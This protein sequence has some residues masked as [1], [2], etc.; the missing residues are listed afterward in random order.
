M[1]TP[2]ATARSTARLLPSQN[3]HAL[4]DPIRDTEQAVTVPA[5]FRTRHWPPFEGC[6][7]VEFK[8]KFKIY[9]YL[10][11]R[12]RRRQRRHPSRG[13]ASSR[14][15][16]PACVRCSPF[17]APWYDR[18]SACC[19]FSRA[20]VGTRPSVQTRI[21]RLATPKTLCSSSVGQHQPFV[22]GKIPSVRASYQHD[23]LPR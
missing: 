14:L 6:V 4:H 20:C 22:C 15:H 1:L 5:L 19:A 21:E 2:H 18:R 10:G 3:T 8:F 23:S 9:M 11:L 7:L 17:T 13:A 12:R 16:Q